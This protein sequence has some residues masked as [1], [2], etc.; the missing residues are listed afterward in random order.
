MP[1]FIEPTTLSNKSTI[2]AGVADE[3]RTAGL[4]A[5][6]ARRRSHTAGS[7]SDSL[8]KSP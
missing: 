4:S 5:Q 2:R 1:S 7:T 8:I 3:D 6:L